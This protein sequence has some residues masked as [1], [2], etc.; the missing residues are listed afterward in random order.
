MVEEFLS[1]KGI[2]FEKRDVAANPAY[3][4]ELVRNTGQMGVPVTI[5]DGQMVVGFDRAGLEA[6][7][8]PG[9]D[10]AGPSLGA[11]VGDA[12]KITAKQGGP[13]TFG[14]Y[15]GRVRPGSAAERLGLAA[16]DI[17]IEFNMRRIV[18]ARDLEESLTAMSPGSRFT[19]VFLRGEATMK[20]EGML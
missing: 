18:K 16:G 4:E 19:L 9:R 3:A 6:L 7:L 12:S 11:A 8:S 17:I 13:A 1:R 5:I 14:A 15:V 10:S 2:A 20:A